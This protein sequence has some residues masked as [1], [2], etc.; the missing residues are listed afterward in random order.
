MLLRLH[1]WTVYFGS[2]LVFAF[3]CAIAPDFGGREIVYAEVPVE[4]E[5][6]VVDEVSGTFAQGAETALPCF[7]EPPRRALMASA[8]PAI[9]WH[10]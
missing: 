6:C 2:A 3:L 8:V 7:G 10:P 9:P 5:R 4:G 1:A